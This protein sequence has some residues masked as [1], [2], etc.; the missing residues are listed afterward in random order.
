[1]DWKWQCN[2]CKI[3]LEDTQQVLRHMIMEHRQA[4]LYATPIATDEWT[5]P[6][7]EP[8]RPVVLATPDEDI[9]LPK[10]KGKAKKEYAFKEEDLETEAEDLRI[11]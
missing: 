4:L 5:V 2:Y 6:K 3:I 8:K 9:P 1:M 7:K 11:D 10:P